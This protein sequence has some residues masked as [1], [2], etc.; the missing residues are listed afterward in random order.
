MTTLWTTWENTYWREACS[1][2]IHS[3]HGFSPRW[4]VI[5]SFKWQ[6]YVI[7]CHTWYIFTALPKS[8]VFAPSVR[9]MCLFNIAFYLIF[10]VHLKKIM[11]QM[12]KHDR[13]GWSPYKPH[14]K[15]HQLIQTGEKHMTVFDLNAGFL[16]VKTPGSSKPI[17]RNLWR[18]GEE[19]IANVIDAL[20]QPQFK[21]CWNI[22]PKHPSPGRFGGM[23]PSV[24]PYENFCKELLSP[25]T[26]SVRRPLTNIRLDVH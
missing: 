1:C 23:F 17:C 4:L 24:C 14:A 18:M 21:F 2:S 6:F 13:Y 12:L 22:T 16:L 3:W 5:C 15:T 19:S 11:W 10:F 20:F 8:G 25:Q 9:S 26:C 7:I